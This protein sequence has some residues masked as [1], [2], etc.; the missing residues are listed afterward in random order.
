M[1][2][3]NGEVEQCLATLEAGGVI[4]YPTDTIWGLGCDATN[5]TAVEKLISIKG[6]PLNKGLITLLA[7]ERDLLRYVANLDMEVLNYLETVEKPTTVIYEHGLEVADNVLNI[8]G[9]IAIRL[10]KEDFCRHLLKRFKKPVVSTSAN[11]H[12]QPSPQFFKDISVELLG[13]VDYVVKYRQEDNTPT[14]A[15]R[16]VKW[17]NNSGP[18]IIRE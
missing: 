1:I 3:F 9:S 14:V 18:V 7:N 11:L 2:D 8:D 12:T 13:L 15:S 10:V 5:T 6:K 16:I 4:L 17:K